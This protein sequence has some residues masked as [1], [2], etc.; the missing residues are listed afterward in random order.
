MHRQLKHDKRMRALG[1]FVAAYEAKHGVI[2][3]AEMAAA[4]RSA[5]T[6]A[7]VVRS[8]RPKRRGSP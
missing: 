3:G 1:D 6:R 8:P 5:R 7:V 4:T 2:T